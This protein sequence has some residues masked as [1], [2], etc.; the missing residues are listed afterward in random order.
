MINLKKLVR[1]NIAALTPYKCARYNSAKGIMLD[2]NENPYGNLN[3]YPDPYSSKVRSALANLSCVLEKQ[4]F[5]SNGSDEVIDL[6]IRA[7]CEPGID[8]IF[9]KKPSYGM[10]DVSASINNIGVVDTVS[11]NTKIIFLCSPNNPTGELFDEKE[12][13]DYCKNN[14]LVVVDE[15]YIEFASRKSLAKKIMQ[16]KNLIVLRTL[17]KAWGAA[18]IRLGYAIAD[19]FVVDVL[20]KIKY[21]YNISVLTQKMA[22]KILS[23]PEV[24]ERRVKTIVKERD[25]VFI[26]LKKLGLNV[27]QSEANFLLFKIGGA[28]EVQKKLEILGVIIRDRT[29]DFDNCLRVTI[30]TKSENNKFLNALKKCLLKIAFVDRDGT[31]IFEPQ[32]DFQVDSLFKYKVLDGAADGLKIL[33]K[34]GFKLVMI[35][36][37]NGV[38]TSS[39]PEK[40]FRL[41]QDNFLKDMNACGIDFYKIFICPH[42]PSDL[43]KCRKPKTGMVD[44]F[45]KN[46]PINLNK[47]FVIGDRDSDL[48]FAKN[49][50]VKGFK[51]PTNS[52]FLIPKL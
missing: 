39:F 43:C 46:T 3:R 5:V 22:F 15:A 14:V 21:P 32:D 52:K 44:D 25:R 34:R 13:L 45:L 40:K 9:V 8:N 6:L 20:N 28:S 42:L 49:I 29:N 36:N 16:F 38:G 23:K 1:K 31:L 17:S 41:V 4:V 37:Q 35:T 33:T 18:G 2:A 51:M 50:G 26:Q 30:G 11:K 48:L 12:I 47:S 7:F 27:F 10:Y 19:E 24:M